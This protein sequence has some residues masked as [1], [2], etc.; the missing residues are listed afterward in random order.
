[1]L[2]LTNN[3]Y[4]LSCMIGLVCWMIGLARTIE[5]KSDKWGWFV[6]ALVFIIPPMVVALYRAWWV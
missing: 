3:Q 2:D 6:L 5:T 1:M 4:A